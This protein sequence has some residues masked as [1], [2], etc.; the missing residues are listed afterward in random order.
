M[1]PRIILNSKH[2]ELT[3]NRLCY[4]LI[5]NHNDFS[6][7]ALI[8]LQPR[9]IYLAQRIHDELSVILSTS[10]KKNIEILHGNIDVTF[11]RDDFRRREYPIT[12]KSTRMDF[13]VENKNVILVDDVLYTGRTVR[14]GMEEILTYGRPKQIE[15]LVFIDRRFSRH[16]PIE[17][18]YV[19]SSVDTITSE[20]VKVEWKEMEGGDKVYLYT[21]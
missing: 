6:D 10:S 19:G 15:L 8:G 1:K 14:A 3:I 12:P 17:P 7:S 16:L 21:P 2:F 20:R 13:V 9:G 11:F 18:N 5:E 4:Q